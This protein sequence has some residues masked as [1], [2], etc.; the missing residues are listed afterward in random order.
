[1]SFAEYQEKYNSD[2]SRYNFEKFI[3]LCWGEMLE[4]YRDK[5]EKDTSEYLRFQKEYDQG[6][7]RMA[8]NKLYILNRMEELTEKY[9][10]NVYAEEIGEEGC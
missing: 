5:L 4:S 8:I 10:I 9:K 1:M 3:E 2:V 7:I 6:I